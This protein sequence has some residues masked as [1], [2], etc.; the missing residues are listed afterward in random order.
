MM[1]STST[2]S[3]RRQLNSKDDVKAVFV[4]RGISTIMGYPRKNID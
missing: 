3:L 2:S 4:V 1:S